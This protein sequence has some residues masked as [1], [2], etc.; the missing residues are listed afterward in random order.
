MAQ[1]PPRETLRHLQ[2]IQAN[3]LQSWGFTIYRTVYTPLSTTLWPTFLTLLDTHIQAELNQE[4]SNDEKY[5]TDPDAP[6]LDPTPNQQLWALYRSDVINDK[7]SLDGLSID[8][9]RELYKERMGGN[10]M[11]GAVERRSACLVVDQEVFDTIKKVSTSSSTSLREVPFVKAVDAEYIP[12]EFIPTRRILSQSWFGWYRVHLK[13]LFRVW[14]M[15]EGSGL[16]SVIG[17]G[18]FGRGKDGVWD[19]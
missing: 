16:E 14:V 2:D 6:P 9:V 7:E 12:Y 8:R 19:E 18:A 17:V 15:L 13:S 10:V 5:R 1:P 11:F 4:L 3:N